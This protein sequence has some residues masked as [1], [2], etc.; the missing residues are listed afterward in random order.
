MRHVSI[1]ENPAGNQETILVVDDNA[2]NRRLAEAILV[3]GGYRAVLA[4]SGP[5]AI[6]RFQALPPDLVLLDVLMPVMDGFETLR[7]LRELPRG[8]ETPIMIVTALADLG[9]VQKAIEAGADDFVSKPINRTELLARI[10]SLLGARK[11]REEQHPMEGDADLQGLGQKQRELTSLLVHDLKH[12]LATIYFN[13]GLIARDASLSPKTQE[14]VR[15]ILRGGELLDGMITS[16]LDVMCDEDG[17]LR[18]HRGEV[19]IGALLAEVAGAM[20]PQAEANRQ[21]IE[22]VPNDKVNIQGDRDLLRRMLENLIDN[23]TK[24]APP[25]SKILVEAEGKEG[26]VELRVRDKGPG[27][28]LAQR[29]AV[30]QKYYQ[31]ERDAPASRRGRGLGLV[32]VRVAA[33]AHGGTVSVEDE[34]GGGSC[35]RV[36][37]P[38]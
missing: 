26:F 18:L 1:T 30:F 2:P 35:F 20:G 17:S 16:I 9:S 19:E 36:K 34:P 31:L 32:L 15:R 12:P 25:E 3:T 24:Y 27:V 10:W 11:L 6:A 29:N 8:P 5:E 21:R 23:A 4:E 13:A 7:R 14:K 33:E 28:P 37:I 22:L 38:R